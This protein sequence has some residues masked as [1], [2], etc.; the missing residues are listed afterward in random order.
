MTIPMQQPFLEIEAVYDFAA[1]PVGSSYIDKLVHLSP[2]PRG[3][4]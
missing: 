1:S 2:F 3:Y 4:S